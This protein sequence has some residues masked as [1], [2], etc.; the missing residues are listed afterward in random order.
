MN[1]ENLRTNRLTPLHVVLFLLTCTTT[2]FAGAIQEGVV[3]WQ[4]PAGLVKGIPFS[5]S[6]MTIL[7]CHEMGHYLMSR[8][9]GTPAT[10]P[11]FIP[12][13]S[14]IGT[15]GALIKMKPPI[16]H[17]RALLDI[18]SAGPLAGFVVAVAAII[19][20]LP[21]SE[22]HPPTGLPPGGITL[23]D[24]LVFRIL[25][26]LLLGVGPDDAEILLHPIAF[27]GWIGL[28]VTSLNLIPVGQLDGGHI[29][30]ALFP[31]FHSLVSKLSIPLLIMMGL[32]YWP[33][34]A[35]WGVLMVVLGTGHPP[36]VLPYVELD[37]TRR[38]TGWLSLAVFVLTF[39]PTP[40]SGY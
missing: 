24:S 35:L 38:R 8:K 22:I 6:L 37:T 25:A 29:V 3:P 23:G 18:G 27:A 32:F 17:R 5:V 9:H 28:F 33:G 20:G 12:A 34:W 10:L 11:Y 16:V 13:P 19:I 26:E 21:L 15:F 7:L 14:F 40:F 4:D 31:E 2:L 39:T 36:V 30:F 1:G